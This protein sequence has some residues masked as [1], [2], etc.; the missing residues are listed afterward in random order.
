M[1]ARARAGGI[2][3]IAFLVA[4]AAHGEQHLVVHGSNAE[5]GLRGAFLVGQVNHELVALYAERG[6]L[7]VACAGLSARAGVAIVK[8]HLAVGHH[9][10][11]IEGECY[12]AVGIALGPERAEGV[13][14]AEVALRH[15]GHGLGTALKAGSEHTVCA[16][17][18]TL[19]AV[20]A[21]ARQTHAEGVTLLECAVGHECVHRLLQTEEHS[22]AVNIEVDRLAHRAC[23]DFYL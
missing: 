11:A 22:V 19:V 23:H 9:N 10:V 13:V 17:L 4:H 3:R 8:R 18:H 7:G 20:E 16:V 2:H 12:N 6:H 15:Q 21:K 14:G 5:H 1:C